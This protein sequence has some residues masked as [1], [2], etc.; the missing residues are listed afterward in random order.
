MI[1]DSSIPELVD[2]VDV[3]TF[4]VHAPIPIILLCGG[5]IDVS[6]AE[7][8]SLREAFS[9]VFYKDPSYKRFT[10]LMAED[11]NAF[12]PE[13][14]YDDILSFEADIAQIAEVIVLFSESIG[15]AAEF[16]AF[17]MVEE[18][19]LR[20]LAV[21]DDKHY[22][23]RSFITL[24]P[25]RLL[26]HQFGDNS[27]CVLTRSDIRIPGVPDI[28]GIDLDTFQ[29]RMSAAINKRRSASREHTTF[30]KARSGH[31]VK[32]I[33]GLI[34]HYGALTVG[35][36]ELFLEALGCEVTR[37]KIED[38]L[39]CAKFVK[40]IKQEKRGV[41]T[42]YAA[43]QGNEALQ[44]KQKAGLE[45]LDKERWRVQI[46]EYWKKQDPD[47]YNAIQAAIADSGMAAT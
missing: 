5:K 22:E 8:P 4:R 40:W 27:V 29:K 13:G 46:R 15:S 43:R 47:R 26:E 2:R 31:I 35:E 7:P 42:F 10:L 19:A 41:E 21:L 17:A 30:D 36:I 28:T 18:I 45:L 32:L 1:L 16:G 9:R 6:A 33:V 38:F 14:K 12:F 3:E 34:Q 37:R 11:V 23:Q 24:G 20:M 44:Y 39:L 25:V